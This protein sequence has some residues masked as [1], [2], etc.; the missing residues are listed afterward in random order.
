MPPHA[1]FSGKA[2]GT[3][4]LV[5]PALRRDHSIIAADKSHIKVVACGR[6]W[7]KSFMAT[8]I[9]L[10]CANAGGAVAWVVPTYKN[11]RPV[12]RAIERMVWPL[13]RTGL[14]YLHQAE[15]TVEFP[16]GGWL[17]VYSADNDAALR[18][19]S[20]VLIIGDEA[21]RFPESG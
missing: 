9:A 3:A 20:C 6:R 8:A 4:R 18:G 13:V 15:R 10:A 16:S 1:R 7:G 12:W 19:E 17:G 14:V 5:L 21:S 11:S 2:A